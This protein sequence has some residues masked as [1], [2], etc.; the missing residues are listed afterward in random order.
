MGRS[1]AVL[2]LAVVVLSSWL[3]GTSYGAGQVVGKQVTGQ[4]IATNAITSTQVKDGSLATA[5]FAPSARGPARPT[6]RPGAE[7]AAGAQ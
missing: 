1:R 3:A 4:Q 7:G 6:G 5:D 2:A